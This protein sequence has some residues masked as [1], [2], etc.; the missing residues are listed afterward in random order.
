MTGT[1]RQKAGA[2]ARSSSPFDIE[3]LQHQLV[4]LSNE[5]NGYTSMIELIQES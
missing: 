3:S 4:E 1:Q 5:E 2:A